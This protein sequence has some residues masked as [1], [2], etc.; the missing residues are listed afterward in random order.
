MSLISLIHPSRSRSKKSF[1][2]TQ[3]WIRN[4]GCETELI[5]SIDADDLHK[6]AYLEFYSDVPSAKVIINANDC[7][8]QATNHAAVVS[9]G[10][11]LLYL[12]DDFRCPNNWG[13]SIIEITKN[14]QPEWLLKVDDCLQ[15]FQ[16]DVLTIPIM[17]R[18]LYLKL[19]YMFHPAYRSLW[20]DCDL[21][22][23][24]HNLGVMKFAEH[25]K[26]PHEHYC[27]GKAKKDETYQRSERNWDSGKALYEQRKRQNFPL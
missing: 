25:L 2:T 9:T 17:S 26:F 3:E 19:G 12:S 1:Q 16:A 13:Q 8:V 21:Y 23:T 6:D 15:R 14:F 22:W 24:C 27:N 5:V 4:A 20:V 10:D 7:V 11:I 18:A